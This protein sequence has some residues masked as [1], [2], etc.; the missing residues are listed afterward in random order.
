MPVPPKD[1]EDQLGWPPSPTGN[2]HPPQNP[3]TPAKK[4]PEK[5]KK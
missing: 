2:P 4:E 1:T 3:P 5:P